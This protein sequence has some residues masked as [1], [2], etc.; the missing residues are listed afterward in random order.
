MRRTWKV[1]LLALG[2][3][4]AAV[5]LFIVVTLI[6]DDEVIGPFKCQPTPPVIEGC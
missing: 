3:L 6:Q 4:V 2:V 5:L 1:A